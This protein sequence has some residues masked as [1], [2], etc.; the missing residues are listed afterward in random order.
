MKN[1]K[2]FPMTMLWEEASLHRR[3]AKFVSINMFTFMVQMHET[4]KKV[5]I[6]DC[7]LGM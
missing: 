1:F 3:G 5:T 2:D 7:H 4:V 6:D